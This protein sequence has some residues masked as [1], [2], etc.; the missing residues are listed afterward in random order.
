MSK[1]YIV[2]CR[3]GEYDDAFDYPVHAWTDEQSAINHRDVLTHVMNQ[4]RKVAAAVQEAIKKVRETNKQPATPTNLLKPVK[5]WPAGLAMADITA[6]MRAER[7]AT[8]Q[9]NKAVYAQHGKDVDEWY[10]RVIVTTIVATLKS[11]GLPAEMKSTY[12]ESFWGKDEG[13]EYYV[14]TLGLN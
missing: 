1:I 11:F 6:E 12:K 4:E 2:G 8:D 14:D 3:G 9:H 7:I 5:R 13:T 10:E